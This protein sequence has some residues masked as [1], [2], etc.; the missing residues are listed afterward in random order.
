MQ[1]WYVLIVTYSDSNAEKV[2]LC[3]GRS[4]CVEGPLG[5]SHESGVLVV[6]HKPGFHT[7]W[8]M[9]MIMIVDVNGILMEY[10]QI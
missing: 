5:G 10:S 6:V 7:L 2:A 3:R 9:I 4:R 8:D 1:M